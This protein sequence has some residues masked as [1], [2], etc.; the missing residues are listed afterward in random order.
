MQPRP[1][2]AP[3]LCLGPGLPW[4]GQGRLPLLAGILPLCAM[5]SRH[6]CP[7]MPC[8]AHAWPMQHG[9]EGPAACTV[10]CM[11]A[12]GG[13]QIC[14]YAWCRDKQLKQGGAGCLYACLRRC[15][16]SLIQ[17]LTPSSKARCRHSRSSI[18]SSSRAGREGRR[19][20]E[21]KEEKRGGK[22]GHPPEWGMPRARKRALKMMVRPC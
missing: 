16:R 4:S 1:G 8:M 18:R 19:R 13:L 20:E 21:K 12:V 5:R 10:R 9:R 11:P 15:L 2:P 22:R 17:P 14:I 3:T 6:A 7:C